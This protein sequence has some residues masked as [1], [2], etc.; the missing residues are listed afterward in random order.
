MNTAHPRTLS[1]PA[2][3][4]QVCP[5]A[6]R[7]GGSAVACRAGHD[8]GAEIGMVPVDMYIGGRPCPIGTF[9]THGRER[10]GAAG[11]GCA[12]AS[13][14]GAGEAVPGVVWLGLAWYGVPMPVRWWIIAELWVRARVLRQ[15]VGHAAEAKIR[16]PSVRDWRGCGC[17]AGVRDAWERAVGR[18]WRSRPVP[19][20]SI[21]FGWGGA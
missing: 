13:G 14:A 19:R 15:G 20:A 12:G 17:V 5:H 11:C 10:G 4:C 7:E 8:M 21:T 18:V 2:A 6:Q 9:G 3:M 1:T 16:V